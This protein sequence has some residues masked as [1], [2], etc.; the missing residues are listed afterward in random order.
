M[1]KVLMVLGVLFLIGIVGFVAL[2]FW[3]H[4]SGSGKQE[5][6]F[7]AV[8][9]GETAKFFAMTHPDIR[10]GIDEPVL[11]QWMKAFK[12][13]LGEL[14]G[15][16]A[17]DFSTNVEGNVLKT[18]GTVKF[19]KG[20]AHSQLTFVDDQIVQFNVESDQMPDDWFKGPSDT[21]VY[22][23]RGE[24]L[25]R[26]LVG[27]EADQAH[28]ML[29]ENV[30]AQFSLA[31]VKEVAASIQTQFGALKSIT[32]DSDAYEKTATGQFLDMV[33]QFAFE[34]GKAEGAVR[35]QFVGLK[36]HPVRFG[37]APVQ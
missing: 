33:F 35:F 20:S 12:E 23:Q 37:I 17:A 26:H 18:E 36:G 22:R 10:D 27:G 30:Q 4:S 14:E 34:K 5:K 19:T 32:F 16:S 2:L 6:F 25:F 8:L 28:A 11:A 7:D 13:N 21:A 24:K 29:H 3:A 15:L 9:S 31:K 1:K